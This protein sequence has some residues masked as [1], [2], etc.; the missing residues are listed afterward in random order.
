MRAL[1]DAD[2]GSVDAR[3]TGRHLLL[4]QLRARRGGDDGVRAVVRALC[5]VN[6][7][8][9]RRRAGAVAFD[10]VWSE[11]RAILE[12]AGFELEVAETGVPE[13][14]AGELAAS[15]VRS[16][17]EAVIIAGG[18]GTLAPAATALI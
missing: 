11:I 4:Q 1:R 10:T 6:P 14:E 5:I 13:P 7:R 17:H 12:R 2:R 16:G 9:G 3:D 18:D 8:A 15:A